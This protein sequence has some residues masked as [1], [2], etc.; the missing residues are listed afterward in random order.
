M[1]LDKTCVNCHVMIDGHELP[2]NLHVMSMKDN[3]VILGMDW[4]SFTHTVECHGNKV[5]FKILGEAEF[6]CFKVI[7]YHRLE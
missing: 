2:A 7:P 4:L 1:I 3:N 6:S 5:D